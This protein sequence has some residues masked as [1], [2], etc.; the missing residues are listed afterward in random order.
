MK[1][2]RTFD[3]SQDEQKKRG[4]QFQMGFLALKRGGQ[5]RRNA[6]CKL[7]AATR[8]KKD[9]VSIFLQVGW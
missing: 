9:P 2:E 5:T 7:K 1:K 8:R 3:C 6:H 4:S